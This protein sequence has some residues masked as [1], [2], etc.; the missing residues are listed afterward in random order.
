MIGSPEINKLLRRHL[1]QA[2]RENGFADVAARKAWGWH[3]RS[4]W[5]FEIR[6]VGKTFSEVTSWPPMSVCVW[7]GVYFEDRPPDFI[8]KKDAKGRLIPEEYICHERSHLDCTLD[9]KRF[10]KNLALRAERRRTDI[11]WFAPDGSNMEE[12]VLNIRQ[13]FIEQGLPWYHQKSR[14]NQ[15]V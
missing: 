5:V 3:D 9:Q 10:T 14:S 8:I 15:S 13:R 6:A 1:C 11:W 12:A 7:L 2:L 4:I